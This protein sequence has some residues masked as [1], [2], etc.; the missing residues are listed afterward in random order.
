VADSEIPVISAVGHEIDNSLCDLAADLRAPTPSAAAE[1]VSAN[2]NETLAQ[3]IFTREEII[4]TI[5]SRLERARLL[6]RPF[7]VDDLEHRFRAILQPALVRFDDAKEALVMSLDDRI[8]SYRRR[9]EL[10]ETGLKAG[11]PLAGL[12]RGFSGVVNER[13]GKILRRGI[14]AKPGDKL[15]IRPLEGLVKALTEESIAQYKGTE[16]V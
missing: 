1:L 2:R 13:S 9:L 16:A 10:A 14:D 6:I 5:K 12:E 11:S 4:H 15:S 3:I 7:S 8:D